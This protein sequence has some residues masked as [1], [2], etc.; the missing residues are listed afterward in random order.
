MPDYSKGKIYCLRSHQT[1]NVYIGSTIQT[2]AKRKGGHISAY[3]SYL[4]KKC[5]WMTSFDIVKYG[6]F[7]IE[8][9]EDYPCENKQHLEKKEGEYIRDRV[10]VNKIIVGRTDKELLNKYREKNKDKKFDCHH[11]GASYEHRSGLSNHRK[12]CNGDKPMKGRKK[13]IKVVVEK[14]EEMILI[15][16]N[17]ILEYILNEID[18]LEKEIEKLKI[19]EKK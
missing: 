12:K 1:D 11:C 2:L 16:K 5:S 4:K 14:Q 19:I 18:Y 8:L 15:P 13:N 6:D 9:I 17:R 10:C 3:N 7:Y